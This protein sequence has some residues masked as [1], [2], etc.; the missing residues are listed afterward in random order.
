MTHTLSAMMI[1]QLCGKI[2]VRARA[3]L[4]I[5]SRRGGSDDALLGSPAGH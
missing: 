1:V 3:A 4:K 2:G 5:R